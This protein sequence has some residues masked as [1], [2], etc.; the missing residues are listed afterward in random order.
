MTVSRV[1]R[2]QKAVKSATA[3]RVQLAIL[4][5]GYRPDP[6][7]SALASYRTLGT[8]TKGDANVAF[9]DRDKTEYSEWVFAGLQ[10]EARLHGYFVEK[11]VLHHDPN[12]QRQLARVLS[13]RG[14]RGLLFGPSSVQWEFVGWDWDQFAMISLGAL[15]HKPAMHS[16][17]MHYFDGAFSACQ[18]ALNAGAR[19]VGF[20]IE[21]HLQKRTGHQW[22]GGYFAAMQ[23]VDLCVPIPLWSPNLNFHLWCQTN[24]LDAVL[25]IHP[26]LLSEWPGDSNKFYLLNESAP[27]AH[28]TTNRYYLDPQ[29][30]GAEGVRFLHHLLLR[31]EFGLPNEPKVTTLLG[32]WLTPE[33]CAFPENDPKRSVQPPNS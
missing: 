9:L 19:R 13:H 12:R 11:Y 28:Q 30:I 25:T 15:P 22:L 6:T 18:A 7:M 17:C 23:V 16:V 4:D 20:A 27:S 2:G 3:K 5:L 31:R 24:Q 10:K 8:R 33:T 29:Q 32:R 1:V 14:V 21:P 26:H